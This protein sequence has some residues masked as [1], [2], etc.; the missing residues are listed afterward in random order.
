MMLPAALAHAGGPAALLTDRELDSVTAGSLSS[1]I[2]GGLPLVTSFSTTS[3]T[4]PTVTIVN[5][6]NQPLSQQQD[7]LGDLAALTILGVPFQL[8]H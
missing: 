1:S 4:I 2:A 5:F 8:G 3:F 6:Y 7:I